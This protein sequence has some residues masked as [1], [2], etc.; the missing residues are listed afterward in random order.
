MNEDKIK[1]FNGLHDQYQHLGLPTDQ[2]DVNTD[3]TI[4]NLKDTITN[5]PF[6]CPVHRLNFF[7]FAFIKS[8]TGIYTIDEQHFEMQPGTVY[9]TNP[10]HF[11]SYEW[12]GIE[13]V[14]LITLGESFL[15]EN[16]HRDIFEEFPFLLTETF[17][18][19]ILT[20]EVFA[21]LESIYLQIAKEY[22][23]RSPYRTRIIGNLFVVLLLKIKELFWLD[24]NPIYEGNR[25]S[26]I[27]KN[28]KRQLEKHYRELSEGKVDRVL[29]IQ[30]YAEAQS[31]HPNYLNSVIKTKTGK[32]VGIW[33]SEKTITEA[34][35]LLQHS[36]MSI[37]EI[38]FRLGFSE[39]AHFSN[40]FK[41]HTGS[42][43]ATY[44]KTA[45]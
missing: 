31:L 41:K 8:G 3:F 2:I 26:H 25:S 12:K 32:P 15:K 19:R 34:K 13:E 38:A 24:Y 22:S 30:D 35:S 40:Y 1:V 20:P 43:P 27:V 11:R 10:G 21:E 42:S 33:I 16:V 5:L 39:L 17:P 36:S 23:N 37:K 29:R 44:R 7:V 14:F 9:F 4:F 28:F 45:F 6:E 18:A